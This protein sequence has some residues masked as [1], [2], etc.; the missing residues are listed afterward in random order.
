M[1][2]AIAP[3]S[4]AIGKLSLPIIGHHV[5]SSG[6][7]I[8]FK[9]EQS[10]EAF[11]VELLTKGGYANAPTAACCSLANKA[12]LEGTKNLPGK[13]LIN[14][15][16]QLGS[17]AEA[18]PSFDH[19]LVTIFGLTRYFS[20]ITDLLAQ[21]IYSPEFNGARIEELK[22][23]EVNRLKLNLEKGS[24]ISSVNL[25]KSLFG[26]AHPY[27]KSLSEEDILNTSVRDIERFHKEQLSSFSIYLSGQFPKDFIEQLEKKFSTA[28]NHAPKSFS[29]EQPHTPS[30]T[31]YS[32]PRFIQSSIRIGKELFN[33]THPDYFKFILTNEI[34]GGYF[35]SRLMKNIREEKGYT[36]G[37][38]SSLYSLNNAGYFSISTDVNAESEQAT[39]DEIFK[40]I[41]TLQ[42]ELVNQEELDTVKNYLLGTFINSFSTP[43]AHIDKFK[44][45]N[46]QGLPFTFYLN[47]VEEIKAVSAEDVLST[48]RTYLDENSLISSIAGK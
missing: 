20:N 37:I 39:I 8:Y 24:Y 18:T 47:Y 19:S 9:R 25:R 5:L 33:R 30:S 16:D 40:E 2:R 32:N 11:K 7:N 26:T 38:Y 4:F 31:R 3:E 41:K 44:T 17:F 43:L 29:N 21:I 22:K 42:T 46:E 6:I 1:N 34:L 48:A 13:Q 23:R 14:A 27:G 12:L 15:I 28:N 45:L 36:Y 10:S 35:G